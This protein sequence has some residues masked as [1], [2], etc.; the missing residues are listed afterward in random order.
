MSISDPDDLVVHLRIGDVLENSKYTVKSHLFQQRKVK[1][2]MRY[3]PN[4]GRDPGYVKPMWV[5]QQ[6]AKKYKGTVKNVVLVAGGCYATNFVKSIDYVMAVK[7][8]FESE[9][10]PV[11]LRIGQ[12]PDDDFVFMARA[13]VSK[14]VANFVQGGGRFSELI[15]KLIQTVKRWDSKLVVPKTR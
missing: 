1:M 6:A 4:R 2:R 10:F 13:G 11:R 9:G 8:F 3:W 14:G 5:Y 12:M 7:R 15:Q